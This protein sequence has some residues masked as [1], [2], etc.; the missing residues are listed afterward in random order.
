MNQDNDNQYVK[1]TLCGSSAT[2]RHAHTLTC[3]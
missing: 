2:H 1:R 3:D